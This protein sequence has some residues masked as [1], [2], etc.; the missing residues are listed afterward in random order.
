MDGS[1]ASPV[2]LPQGFRVRPP[3]PED[4]N[5][6]IG[7][8]H[9]LETHFHGAPDTVADDVRWHWQR[10]GFDPARD[11]WLVQASSGAVVA[12]G[13]LW[14]NMHVQLRAG[15]YVHPA[16]WGRGIGTALL[17]LMEAR[18]QDHLFLAPEGLQVT[19]RNTL[20]GQDRAAQSLLVGRGYALVRTY[21]RMLIILDDPPVAP[22]WPGGIQVRTFKLDED[23]RLVFETV[24]EAFQDNWG[25]LPRR[26]EAWRR[27]EM[28][29]EEFDPSLWF[30]AMDGEMAAGV[31]LCTMRAGNGWVSYLAV[32]RPYRRRGLGLAL[33]CHAFAS[34]ARRGVR[35]V[36]LGVD[37][38][39]S[40]GAT[41][42]YE[43]AGMRVAYDFKL[44]QKV[45]REGVELSSTIVG[46]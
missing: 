31:A 10:Q 30:L 8:M 42:L 40:T 17:D 32:P 27:Q 1:M 39:S 19:L 7:V 5:K 3:T 14:G 38:E 41:R 25:H 20:E 16:Y 45:L 33:L 35:T 24:E 34:F 26:F 4:S 13:E 11:A 29:L 28:D 36:E 43:R 18:A 46:T 37:A 21:W 44:F 23:A 22:R 15:G 9:A 12:Y 6:I 2:T